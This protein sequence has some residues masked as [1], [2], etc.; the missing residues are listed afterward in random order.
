MSGVFVGVAKVGDVIGCF[1]L[2]FLLQIFK[3]DSN[4][5]SNKM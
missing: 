5:R 2:D 4:S 1:R 3:Y